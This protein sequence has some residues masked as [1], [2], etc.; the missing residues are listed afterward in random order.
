MRVMFDLTDLTESESE[1]VA[2]A[3]SRVN[4]D[5]QSQP[6]PVNTEQEEDTFGY[7]LLLPHL[8]PAAAANFQNKKDPWTQRGKS[9]RRWHFVSRLVTF[10]PISTHCPVDPDR[11]ADQRR[12]YAINVRHGLTT[13]DRAD[14]W[15]DE[16]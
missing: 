15:R 1:S 10:T 14:N 12:T 2:S 11:L 16:D 13:I 4:C 9:L 5:A 8:S 7:N 3:L 6:E